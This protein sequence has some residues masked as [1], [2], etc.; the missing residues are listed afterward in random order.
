MPPD[1]LVFGIPPLFSVSLSFLLTRLICACTATPIGSIQ[2]TQ[3]SDQIHVRP[4]EGKTLQF[5]YMGSKASISNQF[6]YVLHQ[7]TKKRTPFIQ[8]PMPILAQ[9][10]VVSFGCRVV[11]RELCL[12]LFQINEPCISYKN[13]I[14]MCCSHVVFLIEFEIELEKIMRIKFSFW[15]RNTTPT[16]SAFPTPIA[17]LNFIVSSPFEGL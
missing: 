10:E 8:H 9:N 1:P 4:N 13:Y 11:D 12:S 15:V 6:C 3:A 5:E 7:S 16:T 14:E 17:I 2:T